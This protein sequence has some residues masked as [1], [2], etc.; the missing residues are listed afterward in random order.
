MSSSASVAAAC[1]V[2]DAFA[3]TCALSVAFNGVAVVEDAELTPTAVQAVPEVTLAGASADGLYTL[4]LSDPDAPSVADPKFGEWQHW[5]LVNA[6]GAD[7]LRGEA[8]TAYF[9]SAP[10]K[11]SG[12][13][14][15]CIVAYA[16]PGRIAPA[17]APISA[18]SGFP[19]RRSFNSRAFAAAHGLTPVAALTY[20]AQWDELVPELAQRLAPPA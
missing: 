1:R 12:T 17:E 15:Y 18:T 5:L 14:R 3:P 13:H 9:G 20:R 2:V 7:L 4:I 6:P 10:G 16:Q 8:Q 11:D 19:P